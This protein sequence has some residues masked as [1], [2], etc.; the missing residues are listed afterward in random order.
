MYYHL[1]DLLIRAKQSRALLKIKTTFGWFLFSSWDSLN[2]INLQSDRL[3]RRHD[4]R[5][6]SFDNVHLH[7]G[8]ILRHTVHRLWHTGPWLN[9][10]APSCELQRQHRV[11]RFQ[12]SPNS[13]GCRFASSAHV[14]RVNRHLRSVDKQQCIPDRPVLK[15]KIVERM[16]DAAADS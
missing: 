4:R 10:V 13:A 3:L 1:S 8:H 5:G 11:C 14:L 12:H 2:H 9:D 7:A 15:A 6:H 16:K